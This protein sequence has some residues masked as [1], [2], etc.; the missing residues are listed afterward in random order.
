MGAGGQGQ[1]Q[2]I[3]SSSRGT[4][5]AAFSVLFVVGVYHQLCAAVGESAAGLSAGWRAHGAGDSFQSGWIS[6]IAA[7]DVRDRDGGIGGAGSGWGGG[8]VHVG[9]VSGAD[10]GGL[11]FLCELPAAGV[12]ARERA[13]RAMAFRWT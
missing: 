10:F 3:A 11:P 6:P 9:H 12:A 2:F 4:E 8:V 7:D 1:L 5:P 13:E